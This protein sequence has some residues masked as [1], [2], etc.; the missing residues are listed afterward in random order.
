MSNTSSDSDSDSDSGD[1]D[2]DDNNSCDGDDDNI[3]LG[4]RQAHSGQHM[5]CMHTW[6][7][8]SRDGHHGVSHQ[9][10]STSQYT[11]IKHS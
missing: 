3:K 11:P 5:N 6:S 10:T 1:G 9:A 2:G 7:Q 4:E 8:R